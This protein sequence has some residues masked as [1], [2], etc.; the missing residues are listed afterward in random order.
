MLKSRSVYLVSLL[1]VMIVALLL[2]TCGRTDST[3]IATTGDYH[4][5]NFVNEA[6]EIAGLEREIGNELCRRADLECEWVVTEWE[7]LI[8]D[9]IADEF[10]VI[11]AGMSITDTREEWIDFTRAYYPPAP[12]VYLARTGEGDE[13]LDRTIA[14]TENTIYSDYFTAQGVPFVALDGAMD[15]VSA[16]LNDEVDAVLVDHGYA[17]SQL[18]EHEGEIEIVGPSVQIDR[19]LGIG[20]RKGGTLRSDLDA[21]LASMKADGS[22]NTLILNWVGEGAAT[23]PRP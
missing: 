16:V 1:A 21:A 5:F 3:V 23:F 22:L 8:P 12:S 15:A 13:A 10:D 18:A 7:T 2:A 14:T 17:V 9:V 6:G 11:L 20:V 4:P 19:G